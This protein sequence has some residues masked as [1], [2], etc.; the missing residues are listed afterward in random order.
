MI[1]KQSQ[2]IKQFTSQG[3]WRFCLLIFVIWIVGN[4]EKGWWPKAWRYLRGARWFSPSLPQIY[5]Q[6]FLHVLFRRK[7]ERPCQTSGHLLFL[8]VFLFQNQVYWTSSLFGFSLRQ[9]EMQGC[10]DSVLSAGLSS[11]QGVKNAGVP[12]Y[13][14]WTRSTWGDLHLRRQLERLGFTS[15]DLSLPSR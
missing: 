11:N 9:A 5:L 3:L 7:Q 8:F 2:I 12:K 13:L 6:Q 15:P 10:P 1:V 4:S 14:G